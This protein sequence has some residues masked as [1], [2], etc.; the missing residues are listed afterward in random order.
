MK[1]LFKKIDDAVMAALVWATTTKSAFYVLNFLVLTAVFL[2]PPKDIEGILLV[3]VSIYYQGVALPGLGSSQKAEGELTRKTQQETHDV[4]MQEL[5]TMQKNQETN[6]QML[7]TL[8][9]THEEEL[10][11]ITELKQMQDN[12]AEIIAKMKEIH[13]ENQQELAE[14]SEVLQL[15]KEKN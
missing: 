5:E 13:E 3:V 10:Q 14:M 1:K 11:E 9:E 7:V 2:Q 4:V 15:L 6:A 8:Q 12:L